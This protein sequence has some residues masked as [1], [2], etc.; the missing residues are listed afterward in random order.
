VALCR[1]LVAAWVPAPRRARGGA[2]SLLP[3]HSWLSKTRSRLPHEVHER[4]FTWVLARLAEQGLVKGE[5]IGVDASTMAAN[6]GRRAIVRRGSG[7]GYR[8]MLTRMAVERR[9]WS[10]KRRAARSKRSL[11]PDSPETL[12]ADSDIRTNIWKESSMIHPG[13]ACMGHKGMG[14]GWGHHIEGWIAFLKTELSIT[15][16]QQPQWEAFADALRDRAARMRELR[17]ELPAREEEK[18]EQPMSVVER[19]E[20]WEKFAEAS[21][22]AVRSLNAAFK[23]LYEVMTEEQKQQADRL[24][25]HRCWR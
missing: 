7:E 15:D 4:L 25:S 13:H 8:E 20:R 10:V 12:D 5:R 3:D 2:G 18:E 14:L 9:D 16:A 21:L 6:A 11:N 22:E 17:E 1:Q 24:L 19:L 23:P